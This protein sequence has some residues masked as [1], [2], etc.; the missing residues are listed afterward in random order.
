MR[1]MCRETMTQTWRRRQLAISDLLR[2]AKIVT[3]P[4]I[5]QHLSAKAAKRNAATEGV[6]PRPGRQP[7]QRGRLVGSDSSLV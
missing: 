6:L 5:L 3:D 2:H 4:N 1:R 7:A